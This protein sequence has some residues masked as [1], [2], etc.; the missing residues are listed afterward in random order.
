MVSIGSRLMAD[1][2]AKYYDIYIPKFVHGKL[3]D[4]GCGYVPLFDA[5]RQYITEN[6]CGDWENS[7]HKN[8]YL[9]IQC[10][11][12]KKLPFADNEFD[13]IILSDVLEHIPEPKF[14]L[15]EIKRIL[16]QDGVVLMSIP[17]FY[18]LHETPH[19]YYRYTE[20]VLKK[21]MEELQLELLILEPTGGAFD[22]W[23]D[24]TAKG[25]SCYFGKIGR[26]MAM[27][28]QFCTKT[29]GETKLGEKIRNRTKHTFPLGYFLIAK[30]S[31]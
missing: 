1:V 22:V 5:Y 4:L 9:D 6:I 8:E 23:T 20:F 31:K 13:T 3:L 29:F 21:F 15:T 17:Y 24:L 11:L 28:L 30:K 12:T 19:D 16:R 2:T 14:L 26:L 18:W 10:D 7:F 27:F 25:L